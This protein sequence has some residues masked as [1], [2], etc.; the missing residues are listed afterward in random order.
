MSSPCTHTSPQDLARRLMEARIADEN[1]VAIQ[2][3][4]LHKLGLEEDERRS[5]RATVTDE[6]S[7]WN[8]G[9][10]NDRWLGAPPERRRSS[11][12]GGGA[13]LPPDFLRAPFASTYDPLVGSPVGGEL[14]PQYGAGQYDPT[15][16]QYR[17]VEGQYTYPGGTGAPWASEYTAAPTTQGDQETVH[18]QYAPLAAA[19]YQY[20]SP[21]PLAASSTLQRFTSRPE[22][23]PCPFATSDAPPPSAVTQPCPQQPHMALSEPQQRPQGRGSS[24]GGGGRPTEQGGRP[25]CPF[26]TERDLP[27]QGALTPPSTWAPRPGGGRSF[28]WA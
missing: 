11:P 24:S 2:Q 19:P 27:K 16:Q 3:R 25:A 21:L 10:T 28:P 7:F 22:S 12:R 15:G 18:L 9:S 13:P 6:S 1:L 20:A 17:S 4:A 26:A 23:R 8:V 5:S 14:R